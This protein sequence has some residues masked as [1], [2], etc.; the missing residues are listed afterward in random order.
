MDLSKL[1]DADLLALKSGDLTKVS[2]A[3]LMALKGIEQPAPEPLGQ[4][5]NRE[6][7]S[8][9][10]QLGLTARYGIEGVGD[11]LE[12][13]SSP[14]RAGL[15]AIL[16]N[17]SPTVTDLVTG[18]GQPKAA[19]QPG[20]GKY[21]ADKLGLPTP[22]N[23]T[24]RTV[25]SGAKLMAAGAVPV[26]GA[27]K[28]AQG[29]TG[30]TKSVLQALGT[31]AGSQIASAG[32][33][34]LAGQYV[35][36]TGGNDAAQFVASLGAGLAAP[37]AINKAQQ[38]GNAVANFAKSKMAQPQQLTAQVDIAIDN[39][40]K[41]SGVTLGELPVNVKNSI[42]A[43]VQKA[44]STSGTLSPDAIRRLADYRLTGA[45]PTAASLTLDPAMVSQQKNLAK[46]GVN[47]KDP[48]AQQLARIENEN[49]R[50]LIAGLNDLG[51]QN[52]PGAYGAGQATLGDLQ[53]YAAAQRRQITDLYSA[54]K[55]SQ[56]RA[57]SLDPS[58]FSQTAN[59][60]LDHNLKG[61]FV[62]DNIRTMMNDF[63][64]GR[65][66]LNVHSAEQFKTIIGNA[67]R[68]AS[69]GNVRAALGHIREALDNT[70]LIGDAISPAAP[71]GGNQLK[72]AGGLSMEQRQNI[73]QDTIDAF[74]RARAAN[75][76][77]M[78]ELENNPALAAAV[79]DVAPDKFFQRFVVSGNA[80]DLGALLR[81]APNSIPTIKEEVV[82][83]L[84][85]KALNGAAD[86]VGNFSQSAFN[87]ALNDIGD[88][89]LSMLFNREELSQLR[90]IGRVASYEQVQPKGAAVNNSNTA[91]AAIST[92]LDRVADSPL[93]SKIPFGQYLASP[94]QNI[95]VGIKSKEII[96]IPRGLLAPQL[97]MAN[98][99]PAGLLMSPAAFMQVDEDKRRRGLLAP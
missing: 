55:D 58:H 14:I 24:E 20:A 86:E 11:T 10:R 54:A 73:G 94:A 70:P 56:G 6:I 1:S 4:R 50:Q 9:P 16:P 82:N 76:Q 53:S 39:A 77:F 84:K 26:A 85:S 60:L 68:G 72:T 93:L 28:L 99:P 31:N 90:A 92:I 80:R 87:K 67:Q 37:L 89:K 27:G 65:V 45:T 57:A 15:N 79:D 91:G 40:L 75:R 13:L 30:A 23:A 49:N 7:A 29:A 35:K 18:N 5:M 48:A 25:A 74:N 22:E 88:Q 2:D 51:A 43:D 8:I 47:S 61:A 83:H 78:T 98:Q 44:I 42:R 62:P 97:P 64:S 71:V 95:S 66:P 3:G 17:Q 33:S 19:I 52:A 59:N 32:S 38:A 81:T 69:D 96:N 34:G 46:L 63:A 21:I 41:P 12:F 36:E